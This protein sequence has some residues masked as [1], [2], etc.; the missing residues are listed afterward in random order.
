MA[1][2]LVTGIQLYAYH[3]CMEEEARVG[4]SFIVDVE[5]EADLSKAS[6]SDKIS[7]TINYVTVFEIV[8]EEME[9][10]SKLIEHVGKRIYD[11]I[12]KTFPQIETAIVKVSKLNP[13]IH[14]TVE[15]TSVIISE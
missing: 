11:R 14:G 4:R 7:D 15:S 10:R 13:P 6:A 9:I 12:K 1:K 3:G 5:I 8:K 2:I